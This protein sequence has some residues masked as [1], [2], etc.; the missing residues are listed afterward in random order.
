MPEVREAQAALAAAYGIKGFCYYH[1]WFTGRRI[2]E[3][4]FN[5]VLRT[6]SPDFPFCLCWANEPWTRNWDGGSRELLIAQRYS[7][8]D[9]RAHIRWLIKAFR[10]ERYIRV[11]DRPV[12]F[13]YNVGALP[14]PRRTAE[15]WREECGEGRRR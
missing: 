13:L 7:T 11:G 12:L 6:G 10:D 5:E 2:L 4:P 8:E 15:I 3:M 9:D 1:Y 14:D